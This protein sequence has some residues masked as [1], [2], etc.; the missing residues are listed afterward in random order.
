MKT[1]KRLVLASILVVL[2]LALPSTALANKRIWQASISYANELHEVVGS[3]A[4]GSAA[5]GTNLGGGSMF[6]TVQVRNLSGPPTGAHI[7]APASTS[8][9]APIIISLCGAPGPAALA[10][11]TFSDGTLSIQGEITSNLLYAWGITPNQFISYLDN[12][13][14]YVNVHT[15][16]NPGGEAR[17]QIYPR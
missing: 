17:G 13:Q 7:H 4:Q 10:T 5:F 14:A 9:N 8:E 12:G 6:F 2:A 3:T 1:R 11:C 16:L 15:A